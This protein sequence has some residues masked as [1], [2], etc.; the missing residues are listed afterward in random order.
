MADSPTTRLLMRKQSLGSNTNTWGDTKLNTNLDLLDRAIAGW[1]SYTVTGDATLSWS[2]Y[3]ATNDWAVYAVEL[4]GSPA[5]ACTITVNSTQMR[6]AIK[7]SCGVTVTVKTSAGTGVAVPD[8]AIVI[9]VC[10]ATNVELWSPQYGGKASPT[11]SLDIPSWGAVQTAIANASLPA[12]AGTVLISGSDTSAGYLSQKFTVNYSTPTTTQLAGLTD[13]QLGIQN[14]GASE[15]EL[16]TVVPG[17]VGGFLNGGAKSA[18]F[19]PTVGSAYTCDFSAA[20]WTV[21]LSGMTTPQLE[22]RIKLNCFGNSSPFL[23]GTVNGQTNFN[24][25]PG[26]NGELAWCGSTWGWN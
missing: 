7:N 8:D 25:D 4:T 24:L 22:Q 3:S 5:A 10:N 12:T 21:N 26:F 11:N 19:I 14:P 16:V 23:L 17:Y 1:Q 6:F 2:N 9:L 18:T 13:I 15:K 20:S